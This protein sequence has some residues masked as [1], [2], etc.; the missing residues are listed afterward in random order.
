MIVTT[1]ALPGVIGIALGRL[2]GARTLWIDSIANGEEMSQSGR[3]ARML[4]TRCLSQ[5][6]EVAAAERVG[7]S[8]SVL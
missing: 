3:R 1:G 4:A 8:G 2:I 5:W 7:Y 6:P